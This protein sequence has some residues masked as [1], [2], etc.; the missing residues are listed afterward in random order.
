MH[1]SVDLTPETA[2]QR[3]FRSLRDKAE[4]K[5]ILFN[6]SLYQKGKSV[7]KYECTILLI[8]TSVFVSPDY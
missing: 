6:K 4:F 5:E 1:Y 7:G 2:A 3:S 8:S